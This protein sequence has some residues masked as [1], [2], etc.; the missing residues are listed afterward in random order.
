MENQ[1]ASQ[2]LQLLCSGAAILSQLREPAW[3]PAA[4]ESVFGEVQKWEILRPFR[5]H[6]PEL[7][8]FFKPPSLE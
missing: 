3:A 6:Q 4:V 1:L 2:D 8:H 7:L 5:Q